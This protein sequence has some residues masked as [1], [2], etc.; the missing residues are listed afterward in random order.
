[1][2]AYCGNLQT[3]T[4]TA[5][6]VR[7]QEVSTARTSAIITSHRTR[8]RRPQTRSK[9]LILWAH[10]VLMTDTGKDLALL[11]DKREMIGF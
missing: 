5:D 3:E 7:R 1:L 8:R 10:R 2:L 4:V 6:E 11:T 9:L